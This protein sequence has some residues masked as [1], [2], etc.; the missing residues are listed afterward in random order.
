LL[1]KNA[2]INNWQHAIL[3][4]GVSLCLMGAF[5]MFHGSVLGERTVGIATL[6]VITGCGIICM[7]ANKRIKR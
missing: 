3:A 1:K 5:L 2:A 4:L 6:V 7:H